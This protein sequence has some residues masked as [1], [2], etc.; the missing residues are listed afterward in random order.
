ML[1]NMLVVMFFTSC[2]PMPVYQELKRKL[3]ASQ[4]ERNF[5]KKSLK[6]CETENKKLTETPPPVRKPIDKEELEEIKRKAFEEVDQN[7]KLRTRRIK[8]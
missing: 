5:L 3:S 2:V 4:E 7:Y 8:Q 1:V 6:D